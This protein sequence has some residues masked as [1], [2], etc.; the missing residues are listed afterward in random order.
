MSLKEITNTIAPRHLRRLLL[1]V[2][3]GFTGLAFGQTAELPPTNPKLVEVHMV[4]TNTSLGL[5]WFVWAVHPVGE[6]WSLV[7]SSEV[8]NPDAWFNLLNSIDDGTVVSAIVPDNH[9]TMIFRA[10]KRR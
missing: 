9:R 7:A 5:R 2:L 8:G 3:L 1:A 10:R 6:Y 4:R